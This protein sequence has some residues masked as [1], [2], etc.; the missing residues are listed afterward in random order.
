MEH[1]S[2]FCFIIS[3]INQSIYQY[4][5]QVSKQMETHNTFTTVLENRSVTVS[6]KIIMSLIF[7]MGLNIL[8]LQLKEMDLKL[9][10][11]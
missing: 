4:I 3:N 7:Q 10:T 9:E 5:N 8:N 2:L 11:T 6:V 1:I